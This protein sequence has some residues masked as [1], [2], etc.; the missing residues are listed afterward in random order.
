MPSSV[1]TGSKLAFFQ[2]GHQVLVFFAAMLCR[3]FETALKDEIFFVPPLVRR[4]RCGPLL[5]VFGMLLTPSSA[6]RPQ[7]VRPVRVVRRCCIPSGC[8]HLTF[9]ELFTAF[10]PPLPRRAAL[11]RRSGGCDCCFWIQECVWVQRVLRFTEV[12]ETEVL[13]SDLVSSGNN[14]SA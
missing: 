13:I 2:G 3:C 11:L 14:F 5:F 12:G 8:S 7:A 6:L 9:L 1:A 4:V 10:L